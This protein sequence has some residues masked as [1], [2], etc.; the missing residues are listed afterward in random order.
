MISIVKARDSWFDSWYCRSHVYMAQAHALEDRQQAGRMTQW[1]VQIPQ[2][3]IRL[4]KSIPRAHTRRCEL[5]AGTIP[6]SYSLLQP[7]THSPFTLAACPNETVYLYTYVE[8]CL[9]TGPFNG[10]NFSRRR[11]SQDS[12]LPQE[13]PV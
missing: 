7:L 2:Q 3:K 12:E 9:C 6:A 8:Y 13:T 4:Y 1:C 5:A 11:T 10:V